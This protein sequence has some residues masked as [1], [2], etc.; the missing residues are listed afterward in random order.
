[1]KKLR[2]KVHMIAKLK[3]LGKAG[4]SKMTNDRKAELEKINSKPRT[5]LTQEKLDLLNKGLSKPTYTLAS[6]AMMLI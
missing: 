3:S 1:M 5:S 4:Y 6:T 2:S